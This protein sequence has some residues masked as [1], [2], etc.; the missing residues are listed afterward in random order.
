MLGRPA[1]LAINSD[2]MGRLTPVNTKTTVEE[3]DTYVWAAQAFDAFANP[4]QVTRSNSIAGQ[5]PMVETTQRF[6]KGS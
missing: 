6:R 2:Q 4:T 5:T 3:G 1:V